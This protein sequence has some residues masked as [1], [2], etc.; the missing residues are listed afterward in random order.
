[1]RLHLYT[2]SY[3]DDEGNLKL[4]P[5]LIK[6]VD[7]L[8]SLDVNYNIDWSILISNMNCDQANLLS[9]RIGT[10]KNASRIFLHY[11]ANRMSASQARSVILR[12]LYK[13]IT[14]GRIIPCKICDNSVLMNIDS[15]DDLIN[16]DKLVSLTNS[17]TG[18]EFDLL[19]FGIDA[20]PKPNKFEFWSFTE[21]NLL[22]GK[23][24][25]TL[26]TQTMFLFMH[27]YHMI[28]AMIE[29]IELPVG[30]PNE[31]C[32]D[33]KMAIN[34]AKI[35]K[36]QENN[37]RVSVVCENFIDYRI[38][39]GQVSDNQEPEFNAKLGKELRD[40]GS[41]YVNHKFYKFTGNNELIEYSP[42][43]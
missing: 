43:E 33:T 37:L 11:W 2:R 35:N 25:C 12:N 23:R 1:M 26:E 31:S 30:D 5:E 28:P 22:K 36:G 4:S 8:L 15:D 7:S 14:S 9:K 42:Y 18:H 24:Y 21:E 19:A 10:L 40:A 39:E 32:E 38:H 41:L 17:L 34:L 3:V 6:K 27:S 13:L 29:G 20:N 16:L